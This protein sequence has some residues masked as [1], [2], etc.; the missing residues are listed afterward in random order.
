MSYHIPCKLSDQI[1]CLNCGRVTRVSDL[2]TRR[3]RLPS[4]NGGIMDS[5]QSIFY[6]CFCNRN[7]IKVFDR[8]DGELKIPYLARVEKILCPP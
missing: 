3:G 8:G 2:P 7:H 4:A 1:R 5:W 6:Y